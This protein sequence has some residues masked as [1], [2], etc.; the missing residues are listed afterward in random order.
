MD[1][2]PKYTRK[3]RDSTGNKVQLDLDDII[4]IVAFLDE[5]QVLDKLS[6]FVSTNLDRMPSSR[7]A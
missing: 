4:N 1:N 2:V 3:R 5:R 7:L 6:T